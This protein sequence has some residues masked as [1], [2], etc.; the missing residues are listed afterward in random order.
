MMKKAVLM[1]GLSLAAWGQEEPVNSSGPNARG[2][3]G[4]PTQ[5]VFK[6]GEDEGFGLGST[7]PD[8]TVFEGSNRMETVLQGS[9]FVDNFSLTGHYGHY[10][11][12]RQRLML[13]VLGGA[14]T[15]SGDLDYS[16][17]PEGM[18][19]FFSIYANQTRSLTSSF[20]QG[21]DV[22]L[23]GDNHDPW[24]YRTA[25]GFAYSTDPS[26]NFSIS[27]GLLF[28]NISIHDGAFSGRVR[29]FD[30]L[31]NPLTVSSGG[32]DQLLLLRAVGLYM[33]V[34]DLRFP[35]AGQKFRFSAEQAI[36]VG[37]AQVG[38]SRFNVNLTHFQSLGDPTLVL[39]LQAG[40]IAGTPPPYEAYNL[41]GVNSVRGYQLGELGGGSSFLQSSAELRVP[42]GDLSMFGNEIPVRLAAFVDYGTAFGT[43]SRV[44]G[45]PAIVRDKP[46]S[47]LGYGLG[48]QALTE[49]G[50]L[51]LEG[52]WAHGGRSTVNLSIGDRY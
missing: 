50:L 37:A 32:V 23:P 16:F 1:I 2:P 17:V 18:D 48:V 19:G 49:F 6:F 45:R 30:R 22:G 24:V 41:G 51:R 52:A 25:T 28:E 34:D 3:F 10:F 4:G 20:L 12:P 9:R 40:T 31:G 13:T 21:Q 35:M 36:P 14:S 46:D 42:L 29:P 7:L 33:D 39:N 43:A 38:M 44:F 47:G 11:T 8:P 26:Q 27:T 15:V 5:S